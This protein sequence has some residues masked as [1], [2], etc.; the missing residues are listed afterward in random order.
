VFLARPKKE[1]ARGGYSRT[2]HTFGISIFLPKKGVSKAR[3]WQEL[4]RQTEGRSPF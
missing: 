4:L 3:I 2:S 1:K